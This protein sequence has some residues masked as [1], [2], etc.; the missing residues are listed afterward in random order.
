[1]ELSGFEPLTS[2]VRWKPGHHN[3]SGRNRWEGAWLRCFQVAAGTSISRDG[4]DYRPLT[5]SGVQQMLRLLAGSLASRRVHPHLF[6]HSYTTHMLRKGMNPL[7]LQQI[8]GQASLDMITNVYSHLNPTDAY[9][10]QL[11]ALLKD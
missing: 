5:P 11:R 8:L 1:M 2:W 3:A 9:D 7:I 10:A 6:R 4:A